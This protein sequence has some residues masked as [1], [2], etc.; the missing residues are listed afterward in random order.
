MTVRTANT[1]HVCGWTL[2]DECCAK[3]AAAFADNAVMAQQCVDQAAEVLYSLSGRQYGVCEVTVRPCMKKCLDQGSLLGG[4]PWTPELVGGEWFNIPC[5]NSCLADCACSEICE[6]KLP[7]PVD[8]ITEIKIDGAVLDE[9]AYRVDY[10]RVLV[11]LDG[12]CWPTCQDMAAATD[13]PDTFEVTYAKGRPLPVG[14]QIGRA[15]V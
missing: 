1:P 8:S 15:H 9:A 11:R 7:G 5:N 3:L 2:D 10:R 12:E 6:L 14:G 13:Q 4:F